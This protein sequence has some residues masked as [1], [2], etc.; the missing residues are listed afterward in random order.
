MLAFRSCTD[1]PKTPY[2]AWLSKCLVTDDERRSIDIVNTLVLCV[3]PQDI[4][5]YIIWIIFAG[6]YFDTTP[7]P[8]LWNN[9]LACWLRYWIANQ[10]EQLRNP[11]PEILFPTLSPEVIRYASESYVL[12]NM[13]K[14]VVRPYLM[15]TQG[16]YMD[17][18][19]RIDVPR[20][21]CIGIG[22]PP[23]YDVN[24]ITSMIIRSNIALK[25]TKV[26]HVNV[27]S[28]HKFYCH[29]QM[30]VIDGE[31]YRSTITF[32][33]KITSEKPDYIYLLLVD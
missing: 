3:L 1:P 32:D 21:F 25:K 7:H 23:E 27:F 4:V 24:A 33:M 8:E 15:M 18:W 9:Q 6:R 19:I 26:L 16:V 14:P 28:G 30:P 5:E 20:D 13:D 17:Y 10:M 29:P 2:T 11:L 12:R 22:F 31:K